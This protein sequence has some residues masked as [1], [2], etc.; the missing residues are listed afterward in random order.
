MPSLYNR[1]AQD[2][3][4]LSGYY[5]GGLISSLEHTA[6][7]VLYSQ[8]SFHCQTKV[9]VLP[10]TLCLSPERWREQTGS[11]D[12]RKAEWVSNALVKS[13]CRER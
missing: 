10:A 11:K 1:P 9:H 2:F 8:I 13:E 7:K 12:P 4:S 3:P 5:T 6:S